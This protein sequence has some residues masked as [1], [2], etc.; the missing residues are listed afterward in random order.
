MGLSALSNRVV[1]QELSGAALD[2]FT[3]TIRQDTGLIQFHKSIEGSVRVLNSPSLRGEILWSEI[4]PWSIL[5]ASLGFEDSTN[6]A[7][8]A[9]EGLRL[10]AVAIWPEESIFRN[11][12]EASSETLD[13]LFRI[14]FEGGRNAAGDPTP[15]NPSLAWL[16]T[17]PNVPPPGYQPAINAQTAQHGIVSGPR[18]SDYERI[19]LS[20]SD[21]EPC[22]MA[23]LAVQAVFGVVRS[24]C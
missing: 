24:K 11:Q 16:S 9:I 18:R 2:V 6:Q 13:M 19:E 1:D 7:G 15:G 14:A 12:G 8:G 20:L 5:T 3:E 21:D 10:V 17:W 23:V 22:M 4:S